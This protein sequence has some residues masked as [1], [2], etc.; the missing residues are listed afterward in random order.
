MSEEKKEAD[1]AE[2]KKEK[3]PA[4]KAAKTEIKPLI[5]VGPSIKGTELRTF[6]IF[7]DGIP[8]EYKEN[9]VV[10]SLFVPP[11]KLNEARAEVGR[12]GSKLNVFYK[13]VAES[14]KGG[15]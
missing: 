2:P 7:A 12:T 15:K 3:A 9:A 13:Q 11:E 1:P 10:R 6:G 5:Y 14:A 8:A 4:K